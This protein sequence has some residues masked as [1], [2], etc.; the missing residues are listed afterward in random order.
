MSEGRDSDEDL[1][2][3]LEYAEEQGVRVQ[4][5]QREMERLASDDVMERRGA[6]ADI[7]CRVVWD[8]FKQRRGWEE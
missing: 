7:A 3:V 8:A 5:G 6:L 1:K 4:I 2:D